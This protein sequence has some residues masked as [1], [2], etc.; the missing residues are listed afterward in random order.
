MKHKSWFALMLVASLATY[1]AGNL[2]QDGDP[3]FEQGE[4]YWRP[5][6]NGDSAAT[7]SKE[8]GIGG[9]GALVVSSLN[10][11]TTSGFYAKGFVP[12]IGGRQYTV[13]ARYKGVI[14]SGHAFISARPWTGAKG[15]AQVP[16]SR[17]LA[18]IQ[19]PA[20]IEASPDRWSSVHITFT[21]P[22][23]SNA[24]HLQ[25]AT[26]DF[27]G[28]IA[29]DDIAV[30]ELDDIISIPQV[31][32]AP[33]L[34]GRLDEGFLKEATRFTDFM[35]FPLLDGKLYPEQTEVYVGMTPEQL[36]VV[37]LLHHKP[38]RVLSGKPH[39]RDDTAVFADDSVEFFITPMANFNSICHFAFNLAGATY[40]CRDGNANWNA[41]IQVA[42]GKVDDGCDLLEFSISLADL[43]Y[44]HA[45]DADLVP[46]DFKMNFCRNSNCSE[47]RYSTWGRVVSRFEEPELFRHFKGLGTEFGRNCS[48]RNWKRENESMLALDVAKVCWQI[49]KP[50]YEELITDKPHPESGESAYIWMQP[51][52][53]SNAQ[54]GLQYGVPYSRKGMLDIY[55]AHRLHPFTHIEGIKGLA[56]WERATG[57][58]H[59]LYFPYY[60]HDWS[61]PY[62]PM[63]YAKM[64][65]QTRKA[66]EEYPDT[67]WAI[68]LGD[69]AYEWLLYHFIDNAND[70]KK[71]EASP[72]LREAIRVVKEQYGFGKYG[73][74]SSSKG[75]RDQRFE[76]RATK[77]YMFARTQQMQRDLY[78]LCQEFRYHGKPLVCI[79]GD[80]MGGLGGVQQQSRDKN[81]CDVFTGQVVPAATQWRQNICFTTKILKDFTGKSVW[82][83]AHI[84]PYSRSNDAVTTAEYLSQV[85]RAGGSGLQ[86]WNYDLVNGNR[87]MGS[88]RF[89]YFGH[90]PRWEV[91]ME[92]VDRFRTMGQLR[93]PKDEMAIYFSNDTFACYRNP[94]CDTSE[95]L[96]T[97]AGP[98]AG[99]WF[100][101]ICGVQLRDQEIDLNAWKVILFANADVEYVG[102]Q[103]AFLEYVRKGGTLVCFDPT[104]F[105]FNE[106]GSD[107]SNNREVI[108]GSKSVPKNLFSGFR[109]AED[110]LS[111]G[112][113]PETIFH[114][115][116]LYALEPLPGT[117]TLAAFADGEVAATVKDYPGG[118]RAVLFAISPTSAMVSSKQWRDTMKQFIANLGIQT[119]QDIWRFQ[120]PAKVETRPVFKETC[121]T[122]NHFYWYLNEPV[123]IANAS[124]ADGFYTYSVAPDGDEPGRKYAFPD[125]NLCNRIKALKI[126]DYFNRHNALLIKEGKIS[127]RM[128]FDTW[129]KT[130]AFEIDVDLGREATLSSVKLF[131]SGNLPSVTVTLPGGTTVSSEAQATPEVAKLEIPIQG[132]ARNLRISIP[133]R[134]ASSNVD[135]TQLILSEM[136]IWGDVK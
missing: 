81:Y 83:C 41:E 74:P 46:L 121:L 84:E 75:G 80:P 31:T 12:I 124:Y 30:Y 113:S 18:A 32:Q 28:E 108:F 51:L 110:K 63:V 98:S 120:F 130:D 101:F 15:K 127:T 7:F 8:A 133:K 4:K 106:D 128:F 95:A 27:C 79:S 1:G 33:V 53:S 78:Q 94:P 125:G 115:S 37:Y 5:M 104:A 136:E 23:E 93:Y 29:F 90:Y 42:S 64:F 6:V 40:D 52:E 116:S 54:F 117:R 14:K 102:N 76:W 77:N 87:R 88:T 132:R 10:G 61:A 135:Y 126:G 60:I 71:L 70:P 69:E 62:N 50:L 119:D 134:E 89:D 65:E 39:S 47:A 56:E 22:K 103:N 111:A 91:L 24:V 86:I 49:E 35:R 19:S 109:F 11:E 45:V 44:K 25:L 66:L 16:G 38:G 26:R 85:A 57:I 107:S 36:Y 82:T 122:S 20:I 73:V 55:K 43:G 96:F 129:T 92:T 72:E 99:A 105:S 13:E 100:K 114:A 67:V 48:D 3:G 112:I 58:G 123:K 2:R 17:S 131:F 68:S 97:F 21:A 118:G 9:T 34:D 59:C